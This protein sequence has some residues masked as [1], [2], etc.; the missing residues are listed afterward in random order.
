LQSN[1]E[2]GPAEALASGPEWDSW[3]V[4]Q[5]HSLCEP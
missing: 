3:Q 1:V 5:I 2:V 4:N